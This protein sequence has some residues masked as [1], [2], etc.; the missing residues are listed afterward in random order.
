MEMKDVSGKPGLLSLE[1]RSDSGGGG[2]RH[3]DTLSP[4][5]SPPYTHPHP[6]PHPHTHPHL[7]QHQHHHP[8]PP[9]SPTERLHHVVSGNEAVCDSASSDR[10]AVRLTPVCESVSDRE[11]EAEAVDD[12]ENEDCEAAFDSEHEPGEVMFLFHLR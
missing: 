4:P 12:S 8:S 1:K 10:S 2:E 9:Q 6:H 7:H 3:M 5:Q 11:S